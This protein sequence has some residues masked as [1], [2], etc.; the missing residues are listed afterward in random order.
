MYISISL[1]NL[2]SPKSL[3]PYHSVPTH[4]VLAVFSP[5]S[6]KFQTETVPSLLHKKELYKHGEYGGRKDIF[7][8]GCFT[9]THFRFRRVQLLTS[10]CSSYFYPMFRLGTTLPHHWLIHIDIETWCS[11]G[12]VWKNHVQPPWKN[13]SFAT[14]YDHLRKS[15]KIFCQ[16]LD[17]SPTLI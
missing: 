8:Y 16:I 3:I 14:M 12:S 5:C 4:Q 13:N 11:C 1:E 7:L 6:Y 15:C 17:R 9:I 2:P 10:L